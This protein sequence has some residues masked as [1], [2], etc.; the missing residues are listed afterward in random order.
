MHIH[1]YKYINNYKKVATFINKE[2]LMSLRE[3]IQGSSNVVGK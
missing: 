2:W 1:I 3:Y